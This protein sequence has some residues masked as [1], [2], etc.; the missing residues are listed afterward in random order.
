[1]KNTF[2]YIYRILKYSSEESREVS[3]PSRHHHH[4]LQIEVYFGILATIFHCLQTNIIQI[5]QTLYNLF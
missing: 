3:P 5:V 1:M 2:K 4:V